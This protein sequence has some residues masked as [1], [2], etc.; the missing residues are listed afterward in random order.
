M[1]WELIQY[2]ELA[3]L[4]RESGNESGSLALARTLLSQLPEL[5]RRAPGLSRFTEIARAILL[6]QG[7]DMPGALAA[8][9]R[10]SRVSPMPVWWIYLKD[11][12]DFAPLRAEPR[13]QA[14]LTHAR[15]HAAH[16]SELLARMRSGDGISG[17]LQTLPAEEG[18]IQQS[19]SF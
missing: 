14:L 16:Q 12:P 2:A 18:N 5:E 4:L 11:Y 10:A 9:E 7:A 6:A 17:N 19:A 3:R 1:P 15:K 13:F 8:L